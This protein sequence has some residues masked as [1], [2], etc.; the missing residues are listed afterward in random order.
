MAQ[1]MAHGKAGRW[2]A[3][4][5]QMLRTITLAPEQRL[6]RQGLLECAKKLTLASKCPSPPPADNARADG[7]ISFI[8][9]SIS[10]AKLQRLRADLELHFRG[11]DWELI[12]IGDARSLCEG[13]NRGLARASGELLVF[14]HDDIGLLR[15]DFVTRLRR[16]LAR[17]D[18]VGIAG[19]DRLTGPTWFWQGPPHTYMWTAAMPRNNACLISL[20]G[21][22]G[23]V[24]E[25]AQAL[26]GVFIAARRS[27]FSTLEFDAATFDGFH[28]YDLD[29]SYR[30]HRAGLNC[31]IAL[32]LLLWHESGGSFDQRWQ[33]YAD[34]FLA[35]FP[36][37]TPQRPAEPSNAAGIMVDP[38][39]VPGI[40]AWVEH[41]YT[42]KAA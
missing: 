15:E 40:Y 12:H 13:Y 32:D 25:N 41:W 30:A 27:V 24:I 38:A 16:H 2:E 31:A 3:A 11:N 37:L 26:D 36:E 23:P 20:L 14:C 4:G 8:V 22:A 28:F 6:A 10:P 17:Y 1:A 35:K 18:V 7:S 42:H 21:A 5:T 39:L 19:T 29:F 33:H 34:R 9:C